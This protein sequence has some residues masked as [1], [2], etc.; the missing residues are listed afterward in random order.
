M[1]TQMLGTLKTKLDET[2]QVVLR[3]VE[4]WIGQ[5]KSCLLQTSPSKLQACPVLVLDSTGLF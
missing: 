5:N 4:T 1:G 3:L 2:E